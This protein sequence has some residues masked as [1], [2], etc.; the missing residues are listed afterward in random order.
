[1][2]LQSIYVS[3]LRFPFLF[4]L[5]VVSYIHDE[6]LFDFLDEES[7]DAF[8]KLRSSP[9]SIATIPSFPLLLAFFSFFFFL[10]VVMISFLSWRAHHSS[11]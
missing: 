3:I 4:S 5:F 11:Q 10:M 8:L 6:P 1:M 2:V 9:L 7:R